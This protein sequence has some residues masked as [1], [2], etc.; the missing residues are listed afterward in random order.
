MYRTAMAA[1]A[2]MAFVAPAHAATVVNGVVLITQADAVSGGVT[3]GDAPGFPVTISASGSYRLASSLLV[4]TSVNGID[5]TAPEVTID[6]AG[7]RLAGSGVGNTGI[8]GS[9]RG[10]GVAHGTVR[11]FTQAGVHVRGQFLTVD[12]MVIADN[13]GAGVNDDITGSSSGFARVSNSTIVRNGAGVVCSF[14]CHVEG[15]NIASNAGNGILF[16]RDG[17]LALG[18]NIIGNGQFGIAVLFQLNI[19]SAAGYG[20]NS[21][22]RNTSGPTSG[23]VI[24]LQPNACAPQ[25]C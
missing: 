11:G 4:N 17:G 6:M 5:V 1:L 10:L 7:F 19:A 23:A 25:A 3:A 20:N 22:L 24:E 9:H 14:S 8:S 21:V 15:N 18:N 12:D 16:V 2:C 13:G